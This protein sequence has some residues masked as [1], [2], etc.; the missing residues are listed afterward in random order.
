MRRRVLRISSTV[1]RV[2]VV[3]EFIGHLQWTWG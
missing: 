1:L 3:G 2:W